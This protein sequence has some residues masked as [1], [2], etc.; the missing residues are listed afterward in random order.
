MDVVELTAVIGEDGRVA[1]GEVKGS[2]LL[3]ADEDCGFGG[4]S[5]EV[6]PFLRLQGLLSAATASH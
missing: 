5:V 4:A 1:C 6:Q 2:R 3:V